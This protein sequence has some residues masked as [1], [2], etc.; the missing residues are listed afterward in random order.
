MPM[1]YHLW[2]AMLEPEITDIKA[3]VSFRNRLFILQPVD[4]LFKY[5]VGLL[6]YLLTYRQLTFITETLDGAKFKL[7]IV[8]LQ[9]ATADLL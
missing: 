8:N 4:T 1:G 7:L 2:G 6:T 3:I 5:W 9:W